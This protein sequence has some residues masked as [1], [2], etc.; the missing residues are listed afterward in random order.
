MYKLKENSV[1]KIMKASFVTNHFYE[2]AK[3]VFIF[4]YL[5]IK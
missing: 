1:Y 4:E 3:L 5:L 2:S